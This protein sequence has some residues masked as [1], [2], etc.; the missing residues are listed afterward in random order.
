VPSPARGFAGARLQRYRA[1]VVGNM[2]HFAFSAIPT[3]SGDARAAMPRTA[4]N[5]VGTVFR[6]AQSP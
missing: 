3:P 1:P 4:R 2:S 5:R 6:V